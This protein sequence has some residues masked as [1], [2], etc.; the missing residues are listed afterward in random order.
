MFQLKM[1]SYEFSV[2]KSPSTSEAGPDMASGF[3]TY[4]N[5]D[6]LVGR[7][8][9]D[10]YSDMKKDAHIKS[11]L[12]IKK[13]SIL[14]RGYFIRSEI[15]AGSAGAEIADFCRFA[16]QE[17]KGSIIKV[18]WNVCDALAMGY[19]L[20][21]IVWKTVSNGEYAG[22][23]I[24]AFIKSK[25]P[26]EYSF[27][28]DQFYNIVGIR[29]DSSQE[30]Y[31]AKQFLVYAYDAVYENPYGTSDLRAC[32]KNY[33][34]KDI[35]VKFWN[36][37]LEKYGSPTVKGSF[38]RG[39]PKA[40]QNELL[41]IL[42]SV[43]SQSAIVVPE[44][45][46]A[47]LLETIRQ[48]DVGYRIAVDFHN[49]EISKAILN[50]NLVNDDGS[51]TGSFALAK[52]HLD[53]LRMCLQGLKQDLEE[54]VIREQLLRP[55]VAY[56]YGPLAPVPIFALGPMEDRDIVPMSQG[57]KNLVE[58]GVL[59]VNNDDDIA[60]IR[61]YMSIDNINGTRKKPD[62]ITVS[63]TRKGNDPKNGNDA[64]IKVGA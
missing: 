64:N 56:N 39:T 30:V 33:W 10:I 40:A 47:E 44:D 57:V 23:W 2:K 48:G 22:K 12:A 60:W 17:M 36:L 61:D 27:D 31:P 55:L 1:G 28:V 6:D 26:S 11:C 50:M 46:K 5:P 41:K 18:L 49:K 3:P 62:T 16:L 38:R 8:G 13:A 58:A 4:T 21:N 52:V 63:R 32:Y 24:P 19:S 34:S 43:Q 29:H 7:K 14:A 59:Q 25:N 54:T 53:I 51:G 35:L 15:E 37:Y 42:A 20:Q 45:M 9:L